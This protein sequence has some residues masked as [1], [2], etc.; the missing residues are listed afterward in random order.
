MAPHNVIERNATAQ[1]SL[2]RLYLVS[3]S[4]FDAPRKRGA[5]TAPCTTT[6]RMASADATITVDKQAYN[7]NGAFESSKQLSLHTQ[8]MSEHARDTPVR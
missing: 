3:F 6:R 2:S 4:L 7:M 8:T 5:L 1:T